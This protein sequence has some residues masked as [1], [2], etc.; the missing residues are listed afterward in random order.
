MTAG[1]PASNT[2]VGRFVRATYYAQF[3]EKVSAP[4]DAIKT[5]AHVMNNFD[6]PKGITIDPRGGAGGIEAGGPAGSLSD[7]CGTFGPAMALLAIGPAIL[8]VLI[9]TAYPETAHLELEEINPEDQ[10]DT[11]ELDAS[12]Y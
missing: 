9:I 3:T 11:P 1:L 12:G 10:V 8:A 5:L 7:H 6:R 4:D 2:S